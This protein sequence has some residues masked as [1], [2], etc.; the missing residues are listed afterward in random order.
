MLITIKIV[1]LNINMK[2][3]AT[4]K[5]KIKTCYQFSTIKYYLHMYMYYLSNNIWKFF[6]H[7]LA[8]IKGSKSSERKMQLLNI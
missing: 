1:K 6:I 3:A 2:T 8:F 5:G 4:Y 7:L